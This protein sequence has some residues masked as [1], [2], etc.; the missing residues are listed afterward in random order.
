MTDENDDDDE[1]DEEDE[2]NDDDDTDEKNMSPFISKYRS[3]IATLS[4][5]IIMQ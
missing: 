5:I 2:D 3:Q 1:D 4:Q